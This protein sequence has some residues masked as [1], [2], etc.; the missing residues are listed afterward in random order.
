MKYLVLMCKIRWA[1]I[2]YIRIGRFNNCIKSSRLKML[3]SHKWTK[4]GQSKD[5]ASQIGFQVESMTVI[6]S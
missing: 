6:I 2:Y 4:F 1:T 5:S 3:K